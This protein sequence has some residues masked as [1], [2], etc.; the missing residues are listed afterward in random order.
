MQRSHIFLMLYFKTIT[1][2]LIFIFFNSAKICSEKTAEQ[3]TMV[4]IEDKFFTNFISYT[5]LLSIFMPCFLGSLSIKPIILHLER[6]ELSS[7]LMV[8]L[9][10]PQI[11]ISS[12]FFINSSIIRFYHWN[13]FPN[14]S[15]CPWICKQYE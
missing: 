8:K 2:F 5:V 14:Q 6:F 13:I 10:A 3:T 7:S 12:F 1:L 4:V 11:T 15:N 9:P